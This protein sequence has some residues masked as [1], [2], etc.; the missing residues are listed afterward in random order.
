MVDFLKKLQWEINEIGSISCFRSTEN[1]SSVQPGLKKC[2]TDLNN[3]L[4]LYFSVET[5]KL[6]IQDTEKT[7]AYKDFP[8]VYCNDVSGLVQLFIKMNIIMPEKQDCRR[9][10]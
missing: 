6:E 8:S 7:L 1:R 5:L 4:S 9:W 2:P 3:K 10:W